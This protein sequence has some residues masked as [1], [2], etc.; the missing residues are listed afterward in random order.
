MDA[1][2]IL[3]PGAP[4][5]ERNPNPI[6]RSRLKTRQT[7]IGREFQAISNRRALGVGWVPHQFQC[8]QVRVRTPPGRLGPSATK[9]NSVTIFFFFFFFFLFFSSIQ[10]PHAF[11]PSLRQR[12]PEGTKKERTAAWDSPAQRKL[13]GTLWASLPSMHSLCSLRLSPFA[14]TFQMFNKN[15]NKDSLQLDCPLRQNYPVSLAA[16]QSWKVCQAYF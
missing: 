4:F 2:I 13:P 14:V 16:A 10:L 6:W 1:R 15:R 7:N 11:S 3:A 12:N 9:R 5:D 8:G